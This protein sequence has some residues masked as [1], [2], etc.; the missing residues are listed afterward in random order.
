M[1]KKNPVLLNKHHPVRQ[2]QFASNYRSIRRWEKNTIGSITIQRYA[3][4]GALAAIPAECPLADVFPYNK[5]RQ[6][7]LNKRYTA[8]FS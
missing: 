4:S 6:Q 1:R 8:T 5:T 3:I 7:V 2:K